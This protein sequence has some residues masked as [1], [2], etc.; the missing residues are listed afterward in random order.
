[1]ATTLLFVSGKFLSFKND[2][3]PNAGGKVYVFEPGTSTPKTTYTTK[4]LDVANSH[5]VILDGAGRASIYFSGDADA[6]VRDSADVVLYTQASV[7]PQET[8]VSVYVSTSTT[9]DITHNDKWIT[10]IAD[11]IL[12]SALSVGSGWRVYL[13]N[14]SNTAITISR[15]GS[16]DTLNNALSSLSLPT[17]ESLAIIVNYGVTGFDVF[18]NPFIEIGVGTVGQVVSYGANGPAWQS[19]DLINAGNDLFLYS[20][21]T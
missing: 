3:T 6:T 10:T 1:M 16:G 15:T 19:V 5:P 21:F 12:P 7:N 20:N 11:I 18:Y 9:L 17:N 4:A 14:L 13:K 8:N 2:G